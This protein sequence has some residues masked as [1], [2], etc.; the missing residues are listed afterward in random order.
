MSFPGQ[1]TDILNGLARLPLISVMHWWF[2]LSSSRQVL[3][4]ARLS[5]SSLSSKY[6]S[7][8][9]AGAIHFKHAL[10]IVFLPL[11]SIASPGSGT[12]LS[13]G[14]LLF[15]YHPLTNLFKDAPIKQ[16]ILCGPKRWPQLNKYKCQ[17]QKFVPEGS[18]LRLTIASIPFSPD[19]PQL[20]HPKS[21]PAAAG[22]FSFFMRSISHS[23][24]IVF[25]IGGHQE[26]N[27]HHHPDKQC[28]S[29]EEK[30]Q[31]QGF[32]LPKRGTCSH[33]R[34]HRSSF[35]SKEYP[36]GDHHG[37]T[38]IFTALHALLLSPTLSLFHGQC[39]S[40]LIPKAKETRKTV[41]NERAHLKV[42]L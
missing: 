41:K 40:H 2:F 39:A 15:H 13:C 22:G 34:A 16:T 38:G 11:P 28:P 12:Y 42:Q 14:Q 24:T 27:T 21:F 5:P 4:G 25:S 9:I 35:P 19:A 23:F 10:V 1:Q 37:L 20:V 31:P 3:S 18:H 33:P 8:V 29:P 36:P 26:A 32:L 7:S 30:G 6:P 17:L